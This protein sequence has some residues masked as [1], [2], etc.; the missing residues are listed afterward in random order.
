MIMLKTA[1]GYLSSRWIVTM[2]QRAQGDFAV[3]YSV[4]NGTFDTT[5]SLGEAQAFI[6]LHSGSR[7]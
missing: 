4:G 1:A 5:C 7:A 6:A 3:T 2:S